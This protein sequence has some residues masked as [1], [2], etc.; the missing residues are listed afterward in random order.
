VGLLED[1]LPSSCLNYFRS[2]H[3]TYYFASIIMLDSVSIS[4]LLCLFLLVSR[5][6][7]REKMR[8]QLLSSHLMLLERQGNGEKIIMIELEMSSIGF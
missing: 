4:N 6:M 3:F 7:E 8:A 5:L 2:L 1:F